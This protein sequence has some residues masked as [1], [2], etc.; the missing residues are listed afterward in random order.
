MNFAKIDCT[1][2]KR[3]FIQIIDSLN[4]KIKDRAQEEITF[5]T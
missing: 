5:L 1:E 4:Q 2:L 3:R